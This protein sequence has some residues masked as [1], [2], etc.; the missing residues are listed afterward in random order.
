MRE[1]NVARTYVHLLYCY[2]PTITFSNHLRFIIYVS[3]VCHDLFLCGELKGGP[4][5]SHTHNDCPG[6]TLRPDLCLY[7]PLFEMS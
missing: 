2:M 5:I 6:W 4:R 3:C 7:M 1:V